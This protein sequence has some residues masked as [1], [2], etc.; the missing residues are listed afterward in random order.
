MFTRIF[1]DFDLFL[2]C[3]SPPF[4]LTQLRGGYTPQ[5]GHLF[6]RRIKGH[7]NPT[8]P[9]PSHHHWTARCVGSGTHGLLLPLPQH[10]KQLLWR[11]GL[12][13]DPGP[14]GEETQCLY[15][16][17]LLLLRK[18]KNW[19][20]GDKIGGKSKNQIVFTY[21]SQ[22]QKS[23]YFEKE[24]IEELISDVKPFCFVVG[25][26]IF[27]VL[28]GFLSLFVD[29]F[30][31]SSSK[32]PLVSCFGDKIKMWRFLG[33]NNKNH[34]VCGQAL[35][36]EP[37]FLGLLFV[38]SSKRHWLSHTLEM[39]SHIIVGWGMEFGKASIFLVFHPSLWFQCTKP[40][41]SYCNFSPICCH[42]SFGHAS[43]GSLDV[44]YKT[45][46]WCPPKSSY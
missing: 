21:F 26:C 32:K 6:R 4:T 24:R 36:L 8:R 5:F 16:A 44:H 11:L 25:V 9:P 13:L 23:F 45:G 41:A 27:V 1:C 7:H 12:P 10:Y 20:W 42:F 46:K 14:R 3:V 18:F 31:S 15:V 22:S 37:S 29:F 2:L 30:L 17:R 28:K 39:M 33:E 34:I 38:F 19:F 43:T 40:S 35:P